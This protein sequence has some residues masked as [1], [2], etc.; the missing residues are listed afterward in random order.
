MLT[1]DSRRSRQHALI[2]YAFAVLTVITCAGLLGAAAL[3]PAPPVVLPFVIAVCMGG[4]LLVG[5]DL[6]AKLGT[7]RN[8]PRPLDSDALSALRE[9]LDSLPETPHPLGL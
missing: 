2:V 7:M 4:P 9:H 6:R 5:W 1:H 8:S 3:V